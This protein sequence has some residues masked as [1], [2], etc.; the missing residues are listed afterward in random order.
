MDQ[1]IGKVLYDTNKPEGKY[2]IQNKVELLG[3]YLL[4]KFNC[5]YSSN[6]IKPNLQYNK[7]VSREFE[8]SGTGKSKARKLV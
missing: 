1:H 8:A 7:L 5:K 4:K 6:I 2:N 3:F